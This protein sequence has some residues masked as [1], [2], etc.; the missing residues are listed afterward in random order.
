MSS[1]RFGGQIKRARIDVGDIAMPQRGGEP[2]QSPIEQA[3][4]ARAKR[5]N[6]QAALVECATGQRNGV[7]RMYASEKI[8]LREFAQRFVRNRDHAE[9]IVHEAFTQILRDAGNFD[10]TRG[11]A[12][13]WV[14]AIVRNTALKSLSRTRREIATG[15]D[16]LS[17]ICDQQLPSAEDGAGP[18]EVA[19]LRA[20]LEALEPRRRAALLLAFVDGR[21]HAEIANVLG[22]PIGTVKSWMRRELIALR[23]RLR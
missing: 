15:A 10:P 13:A 20:C 9:D 16:A 18:A 7:A 2:R 17:S 6:Y 5:F 22:V 12:G 1:A 23:E 19:T 8:R 11:S 14:Y 3:A 4:S 21:T